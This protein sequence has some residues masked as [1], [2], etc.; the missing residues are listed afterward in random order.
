MNIKFILLFF[1]L[2]IMTSCSAKTKHCYIYYGQKG[3]I[4]IPT[5]KK[6]TWV[7]YEIEAPNF[8]EVVE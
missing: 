2:S 1:L 3:Y 4:H 6:D 8:D 5:T 7:T